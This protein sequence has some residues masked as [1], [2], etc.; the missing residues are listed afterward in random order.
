MKKRICIIGLTQELV[1][2]ITQSFDGMFIHHESSVPQII[3]DKGQLLVERNNGAGM[4][5]VDKVIFHGIFP[6]DFDLL[7][8]L[9][10]WDGPCYPNAH[11]MMNCRLKLPCLARALKVSKFNS[12]RGFITAQTSIKI[13]EERV[14]KWGNWHCGENKA[15]FNTSWTSEEASVLEPFFEGE[16]VRV[17]IIGEQQMQIKLEGKD[18]LKSIHDNTANFMEIDQELLEDTLNIKEAF[19]MDMIANDYIVGTN[20]EKHLL[21]VNHIPNVTRFEKLQQLYIDEIKIWINQ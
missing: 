15:K 7:T 19:G 9:S 12:Q 5:P 14:A 3:V 21:E 20:G 16:S 8:G 1:A 2:E 4:L 6:N 11:A 10:I 18:W 17:V 13:K